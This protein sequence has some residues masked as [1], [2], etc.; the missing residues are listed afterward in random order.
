MR[1]SRRHTRQEVREE[2]NLEVM[3]DG[4]RQRR[5]KTMIEWQRV[6]NDVGVR[7]LQFT[8]RCK[9]EDEV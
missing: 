9:H 2:V 5:L 7:G 6:S 4:K 1:K 8:K 3:H